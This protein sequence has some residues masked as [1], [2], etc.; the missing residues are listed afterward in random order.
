MKSTL[1]ISTGIL[2]LFLG[3]CTSETAELQEEPVTTENTEND[4][5]IEYEQQESGTEEPEKLTAEISSKLATYNANWFSIKYPDNF[6][7]RPLEPETDFGTTN[8]SI[9]MR[10]FLLLLTVWWNSS[11]I[12]LNGAV[13]RGII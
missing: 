1:L 5:I 3:S 7:V 13:N 10:H 2:L 9:R 12:L 11:F 8:T 6:L 4:S